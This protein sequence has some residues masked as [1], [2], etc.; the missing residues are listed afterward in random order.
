[1]CRSGELTSVLCVCNSDSYS[2]IGEGGEERQGRQLRAKRRS[3]AQ[4]HEKG[5]GEPRGRSQERGLRGRKE[6]SGG[7]KDREESGPFG[8]GTHRSK[9]QDH[10]L[11]E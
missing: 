6:E 3:H 5:G 10:E 8:G 1:M 9:K 11:G 2:R 7:T 4:A